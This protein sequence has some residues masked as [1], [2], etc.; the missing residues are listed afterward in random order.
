MADSPMAQWP[1]LRAVDEA[2]TFGFAEGTDA[3]SVPPLNP[4]RSRSVPG[5]GSLRIT[6][7]IQLVMGTTEKS[8]RWRLNRRYLWGLI[9]C[10]WLGGA[11][12]SLFFKYAWNNLPGRD[13]KQNCLKLHPT[14]KGTTTKDEC[15][16]ENDPDMSPI[17][18]IG[19]DSAG[20]WDWD[21]IHSG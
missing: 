2:E 15:L 4:L 16:V 17:W 19:D 9:V 3:P 18:H 6:S 5:G 10:I 21:C 14:T 12:R 8:W 20:H 13:G 11:V 1:A 7:T